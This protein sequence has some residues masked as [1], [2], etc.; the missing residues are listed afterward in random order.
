VNL[1]D[2][3]KYAENSLWVKQ[4]E[5]EIFEIGLTEPAVETMK[6]L[7]FLETRDE[8]KLLGK[9]D[10][11]GEYEALKRIGEL[12]TPLEGKIVEVNDEAA[13]DPDKVADEPY[14]E[15]LIR[16]EVSEDTDKLM[17][18]DKAEKYYK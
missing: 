11:I 18:S 4:V 5:E 8:G 3:R 16:I 9:N 7:M 10:L 1:P 6:Q 13:D 12:E 14:R 15:W 2:D 17:N